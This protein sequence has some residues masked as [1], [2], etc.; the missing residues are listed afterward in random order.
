M[1]STTGKTSLLKGRGVIWILSFAFALLAGFGVLAIVGS[2]AEQGTYY[3]INTDVPAGTQLSDAVVDARTAN[4]DG[5]PATALSIADLK[6][7]PLF[8]AIPLRA[9]DVITSSVVTTGARI[10][11]GIPADYVAA[12]LEVDPANA[13]AGKIRT[14]DLVDIAAVSEAGEARVVL[15]G[16]LVI[17]VSIAPSTISRAA[18]ADSAA[19]QQAPAVRDGVPFLYTFAVSP[20]DFATLALL[21][22]NDVYLA[23]TQGTPSASLDVVVREQDIFK[24]GPLSPAYPPTVDDTTVAGGDAGPATDDTTA[25]PVEPDGGAGG[26]AEPLPAPSP[27][28]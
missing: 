11:D 23:L 25:I 15:H 7:Q 19:N 18:N 14:G 12:S 27:T 20:T 3:V 22:D 17:D 1:A 21:R 28:P 5:V 2:A 26:G 9:G 4:L 8:T 16:V 24:S 6:E 13:A 10:V